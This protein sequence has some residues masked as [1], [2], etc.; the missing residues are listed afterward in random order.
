[1]NPPPVRTCTIE[2]CTKPLKSRGWCE[3]H[4]YRNRRNGDPLI[5]QRRT[6]CTVS[7]CG[8]KHKAKGLC[9]MHTERMRVHGDLNTVI[10]RW[11]TDHTG[12]RGDACGYA[13]AHQRVYR[14]RGKASV[15][16]CAHCGQQAEDWAYTHDCPNE[17]IGTGP[18]AGHRFSPD[19]YRYIAL[20]RG[21]HRAF[22]AE[23][24]HAQMRVAS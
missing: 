13:A 2:G 4:Y 19:P 20:C 7:D 12:W 14:A 9:A 6:H 17:Q 21:C 18:H 5:T 23:H 11:G 22:D 1:M 3:M 16:A 24:G 8:R 15:H 10:S